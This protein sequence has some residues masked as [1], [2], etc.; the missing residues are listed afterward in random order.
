M[1]VL[2]EQ[3]DPYLLGRVD[4]IFFAACRVRIGVDFYPSVL[5]SSMPQLE[6]KNEKM[7]QKKKKSCI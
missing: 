4:S 1:K 2:V 6:K 5:N 3:L 7:F